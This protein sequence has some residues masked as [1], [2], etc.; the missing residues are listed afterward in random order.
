MNLPQTTGKE[1]KAP[2]KRRVSARMRKVLTLRVEKAY[3]WEICAQQAQISPAAIYK[4]L[5]QPHVIALFEELKVQYI[6]RLESLEG[7]HKARALEVAREIVDKGKTDNA[8]MRAVEFLRGGASKGGVNVQINNVTHSKAYEFARP[9]QEVVT[10]R[11][12]DA[13]PDEDTD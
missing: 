7:M 5:K 4:G 9:G 6:Q 1:Q 11:A 8:R 2:A 12:A 3:T 10:I 13:E